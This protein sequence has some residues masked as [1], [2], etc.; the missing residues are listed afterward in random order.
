MYQEKMWVCKEEFVSL[1]KELSQYG[2]EKAQEFVLTCTCSSAY[3]LLPSPLLSF[4]LLPS[5]GSPLL[6]CPL[7]FNLFLPYFLSPPF[8][9]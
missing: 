9:K 5:L 2:E 4:T 6:S 1:G 8:L 3:R 7:P